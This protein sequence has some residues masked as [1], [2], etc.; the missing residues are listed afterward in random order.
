MKNFIKTSLIS[1]ALVATSFSAVGAIDKM[2]HNL[3]WKHSAEVIKAD[4]GKTLVLPKTP[5]VSGTYTT[6][7]TTKPSN[8]TGYCYDEFYQIATESS[9]AGYVKK[10][11]YTGDLELIA[12]TD[13]G[14]DGY[15]VTIDNS[16]YQFTTALDVMNYLVDKKLAAENRTD[17][18]LVYSYK[19]PMSKEDSR[20]WYYKKDGVFYPIYN[21]GQLY[22]TDKSVSSVMYYTT[23][24]N[25][26]TGKYE[27]QSDEIKAIIAST[28]YFKPIVDVYEE[29]KLSADKKTF[30]NLDT[31][32]R[33]GA[34]LSYDVD[35]VR[36]PKGI[37]NYYSVY[38]NK[39]ASTTGEVWNEAL[40]GKLSDTS[41]DKAEI[42]TYIIDKV[43]GGIYCDSNGLCQAIEDK[44][45]Y[46]IT[47]NKYSNPTNTAGR[48]T[49]LT[50]TWKI[51]TKEYTIPVFTSELSAK[52]FIKEKTTYEVTDINKLTKCLYRTGVKNHT[53]LVVRQVNTV[54]TDAA[55][56]YDLIWAAVD[57][58]GNI[59]GTSTTKV[60]IM[61]KYA[62]KYLNGKVVELT[63]YHLTG[64][65]Y[66][67]YKYDYT[68]NVVY[69]TFYDT[70]GKIYDSKTETI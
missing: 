50:A 48:Y 37:A 64:E 31:L 27:E 38:S 59:V 18:G 2:Q 3:E 19:V 5:T 8:Y 69:I 22:K 62:R 13:T 11:S 1:L 70:D 55:G 4:L 49:G 32:V 26:F 23:T 52:A 29:V 53:D 51:G 16:K 9:I 30:I 61:P 36:L 57:A 33:S 20:N 10:Y 47:I 7:S 24:G 39:V 63:S 56:V 66:A 46:T 12:P 6:Y 21:A 42:A 68:R 17:A 65:V 40:Y 43:V 67:I 41:Y 28:N 60:A 54:S 58:S 15:V 35:L 25:V 44:D 14:F 45:G 34:V